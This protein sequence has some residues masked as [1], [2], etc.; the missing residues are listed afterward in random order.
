MTATLVLTFGHSNVVVREHGTTTYTA[1]TVADNGAGLVTLYGEPY[2]IAEVTTY[3]DGSVPWVFA[4][5]RT[6]SGHDF[7]SGL[8]MWFTLHDSIDGRADDIAVAIA[9]VEP[10][11]LSDGRTVTEMLNG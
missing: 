3:A 9:V 1:Y 5:R 4:I 10:V 7:K 8:G 2:R 6:K 11:R